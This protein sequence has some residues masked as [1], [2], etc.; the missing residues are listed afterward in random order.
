MAPGAEITQHLHHV[1]IV[2]RGRREAAYNPVEQIGISAFE[3]R[4]ELVELAVAE[5]RQGRLRE[6]AKNEVALLRPAMPAA[7]QQPP[8]PEI[9][10]VASEAV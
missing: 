5:G 4:F 8:A 1:V 2:F 6:R 10:I 9:E 7:E 3:R